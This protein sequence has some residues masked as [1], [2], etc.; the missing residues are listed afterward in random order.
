[1]MINHIGQSVLHTPSRDL[2]LKNILHVP[3]ASKNLASIPRIAKDNDAFL[4]FHPNHFFI[5]EQGTRRTIL[6]GKC[7]GGLYPLK[8]SSNKQAWSAIK[9][10]TSLWHSRLGHVA[11]PVVQQVLSRN[12]LSFSLEQNK[13]AVCDACQ[14]GKSHQ[15]SYPRS[16]SVSRHPLD[17]IFSDVWGPAPNS[18]GRYSYYVSFIDDFSKFTWIYL[19]HHKSEVF[20]R[21]NDFQNLVE[22]L[23]N[24]KIIVVQ[25][26]WGGE[27]QRLNSF[28]QRVGISHHVSCPHAHQQ[29]GSAERKHRHIVEM[30]L[31]LLA[32]A[33][34]PLKYWDQA[35]L[36][37]TFLINRLPSK[38]IN[39]STP[40]ELLFEQT[41]D[42]SSLRTFGYACWP[43]LRPY[44]DRKL[45]FLS[46]RCVFLG[47][48]NQHKG[49]KCLDIATGRIY[50][51]RDVVFNENVF[52]FAQLHPNAGALLRSEISLLSDTLLGGIDTTDQFLVN[53]SKPDNTSADTGDLSPSNSEHNG[54]NLKENNH[55]FMPFLVPVAGTAP[56]VDFPTP[57]SGGSTLDQAPASQDAGA[58]PASPRGGRSPPAASVPAATPRDSAP[59]GASS[60]LARQPAGTTPSVSADP[61][62]GGHRPAAAPVEISSPGSSANDNF[63]APAPTSSPLQP[64]RPTTHLQHGIRKPKQYTNGTVRYGHL[65]TVSEP[66]NLSDALSSPQWRAAMDAE[67]QALLK[68]KTW[69][70]VPP[71]RHKNIIGAKWVFK[72]KRKADGT[73]DR[74]KARLV[75]KGYRQRYG[76]DYEDTFSPPSTR[77]AKC[78]LAR[79]S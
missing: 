40:L 3:Q 35:F 10:M 66:T 57:A 1:M 36:T 39:D 74:Y 29:N 59:P 46:K 48:K 20:Q 61:A 77:C 62:D 70:L 19:L 23:F 64:A 34:M 44:N 24:R 42:Y 15:L 43:N 12:N 9:P 76:I 18:F 67:F 54:E 27:Y 30:G 22:R 41:A 55:D 6:Q 4:E 2:V 72:I 52:L 16:S 60:P 7:E 51:S 37:A 13:G 25:T 73:I 32:H 56:G 38:V 49:F 58:A 14:Q 26:D 50:I 45:Q 11:L 63:A 17:L 78:L 28:F 31:S 75:A 71:P 65:A 68:N 53:S 21:F 69:H 47:Y 33:S 8:S 5:K 79:H